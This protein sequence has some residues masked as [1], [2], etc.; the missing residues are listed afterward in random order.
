MRVRETSMSP[1][2]PEIQGTCLPRYRRVREAFAESF[3]SRGE[4]G[5]AVA[6]TVEGKPVV[7]LF[8]GHADPA[9]SRPWVRDTIVHLYSTT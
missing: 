7:D 5:A 8:A 4:I 9:R 1:S 6:F 2:L 3:A